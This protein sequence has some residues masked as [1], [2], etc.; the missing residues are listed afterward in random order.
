MEK[1]FMEFKNENYYIEMEN[2]FK[3]NVDSIKNSRKKILGG[4][5]FSPP[6]PCSSFKMS[7]DILNL[8][9]VFS[10]NIKLPDPRT[11]CITQKIYFL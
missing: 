6:P 3:N 9:F 7:C 2:K 10:E 8:T 11:T 4:K 1:V 5:F